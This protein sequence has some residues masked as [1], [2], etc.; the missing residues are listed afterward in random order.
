[1]AIDVKE[2]VT[3][4]FR[5]IRSNKLRSFLTV[6]GVIIGIT[7][8]M[9]MISIIEG[10]NKSMKAQ[11]ASIGTDVLYVRPFSPGAFIGGFPDSLRH[12]PWFKPQDAE[13]IRKYC[14]AVLAV[15]PLNFTQAPLRYGQ[16]ETRQ[17]V[18]VGSTPDFLTTNNYAVTAGRY[19]TD[20]EV[21]HRAPVAILGMDQVETLFPHGNSVGK[22]VY[23]GGRPFTVIGELER[24]GKFIGQSLDD[25]VLT[26]YTSLEKNFGPDL[27]MV[28]NAKPASPEL[29]D[30]AREQ[31]IDVMRRQRRLRYNQGDN[32]AVFTDQSLVD[33][34]KQITGAF[35]LVMVVIS[36]IGLLV[37]GIGVMNIMLVSVTER[38]REIGLRKA[39]GARQKDVLWQFLVEAMTLTGTG[40]VI[41]VLVG[42]LVGWL[43]D[44]LTPLAF[45]VPPWGIVLA[46]LSATSIGLFFGIYPAMKAA[47]LDPVEA[48][49]Y[50]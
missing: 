10:L 1:M 28:L 8:I 16:T 11:L 40:G 25:M 24:R 9:A 27:P 19:F 20:A 2:G 18:V 23:I 48:L 22:S 46:F 47:R 35:Y 39:I 45:A 30:T 42:L 17:G 41:G 7:T 38:T 37:G 13:A 33:L 21:E 29:I 34:Y 26:P 15:A 49:R 50:E 3:I 6:L 31:I 12:R 44:V 5:A 36:S 32:F 43:I 4:A 14:D